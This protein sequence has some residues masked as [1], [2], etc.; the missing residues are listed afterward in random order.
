M[1]HI[2]PKNIHYYDSISDN[3]N[4]LHFIPLLINDPRTITHR[5]IIVSIDQIA[6]LYTYIYIYMAL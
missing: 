4:V 3:K 5:D 2:I 1:G 6:T